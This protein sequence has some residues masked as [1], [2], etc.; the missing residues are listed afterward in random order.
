[1][2][3]DEMRSH[4]QEVPSLELG[5]GI[6]ADQLRAAESQL[7]RFP[8]DYARFLREFGWAS[9]GQHEIWGIGDMER[10]L[11]IVRLGTAERSE[12]ALPSHLI[13]FYNTGS[14]D[15]ACMPVEDRRAADE[16]GV[17]MYWH[18]TQSSE[19]CARSF[20]DYI[21]YLI[22]R[23]ERYLLGPQHPRR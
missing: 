18:E 10:G 12:F 15:L 14:G 11:D 1:M 4:L 9:F 22:T 6:S 20:S 21:I 2:T 3:Y 16:A 5:E 13:P 17:Q 23:D 7:G 8:S 19:P